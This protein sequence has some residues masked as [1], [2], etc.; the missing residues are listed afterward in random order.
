MRV[1]VS[2]PVGVRVVGRVD[3]DE[4]PEVRAVVA[5][6]EAAQ[7]RR[8]AAPGHLPANQSQC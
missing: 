5:V 1:A 2:G 7:A 4:P 3:G 6:L 8:H